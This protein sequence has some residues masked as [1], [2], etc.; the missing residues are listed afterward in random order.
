MTSPRLRPPPRIN[1]W[2]IGA[3][4]GRSRAKGPMHRRP[5]L[6][7]SHAHDSDCGERRQTL[8]MST[9]VIPFMMTLRRHPGGGFKY[10]GVGR[11]YGRVHGVLGGDVE[12]CGGR[13]PTCSVC[14]YPGMARGGDAAEHI[15]RLARPA[16]F[17]SLDGVAILVNADAHSDITVRGKGS[18][19]C[20]QPG[21]RGGARMCFPC[22]RE[23]LSTWQT[24]GKARC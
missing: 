23:T 13:A 20:V 17:Q 1:L 4:F 9:N 5:K 10:S 19:N 11:E 3:C 12:R 21:R 15:R 2:T 16:S 18:A 7:P 8:D 6:A 24:A 22:D 14:N